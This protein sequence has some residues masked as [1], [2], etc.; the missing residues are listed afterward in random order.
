MKKVILLL[1]DSLMPNILE[2]CMREKTVPA[3]Q[4]LKDRGRYW[5][6]CVTVFPTMTAS[7]DSSLVTGVYPNVH[8]IPGLIWY[9][10]EEKAII[11][12]LNGWKCV[13]KLGLSA[14]AQNVLYNLNEKQLSKKVTTLFE[15]LECRGKTSASI[16]AIVHR[17]SKKHCVQLPFLIKLATGFRFRGDIS[18][19]DV[20]T[21]GAMVQTN[22]KQ[23][24][25][26]NIQGYRRRFGIND[27]YAVNVAKQL[28]ESNFQPDFMLVY[29]PDNDHEIHKKGPTYAGESLIK[30]DQRIQEILNVFGSWDD[31]LN[32]CV[33][34]VTSDHGQTHIGKE[35]EFNIDLDKLLEPFRVLQL[36]EDVSVHD[37]VVCNNERMAYIYPL[38]P[39]KQ[40]QIMQQL[41][42]DSRID[43]IAW[44]ED[45]GVSVRE[46]GS[47]RK[48]YFEPGGSNIDIYGTAWNITGEWATL[49]VKVDEGIIHYGDYPDVL[50][51]LYGALYS[52]D[53]PVIVVTA[54]PRYEFKSRHYPVHLNGGSHGSLHK[55]DSLIPLIVAGTEYPVN[56]PP[57]LVDLKEYIIKLFETGKK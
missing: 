2:D 30:V 41:L 6:N 34:I 16:N 7:V 35:K 15:E 54:R 52:Q 9:N 8:R 4:F 38:K 46:G 19:P 40:Q 31:A 1:V 45:R 10:P 27:K 49:D 39:D 17:G 53:I 51:R 37:L 12:Y 13:I 29:L 24:I 50:S 44:K 3:L 57:R 25:P 56:E 20:L 14:C 36:G 32:Q 28:I 26:L 43:L 55:Y 5:P 33:F 42:L 22:L 23:K 47:G 48:V 21:L 18:G 11:N